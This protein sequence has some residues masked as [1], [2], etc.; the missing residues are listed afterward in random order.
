MTKYYKKTP[1]AQND[2][3]VCLPPEKMEVGVQYA[4]SWNLV[5]QPTATKN[6]KTSLY[7]RDYYNMVVRRLKRFSHCEIIM[8]PEVSEHGWYHFH[9]VITLT[10]V[11]YFFLIDMPL[12]KHNASYKITTISDMDNI[13]RPYMYKGEHLLKPLC[14][15]FKIPYSISNKSNEVKLDAITCLKEGEFSHLND[16]YV[17]PYS[18]SDTESDSEDYKKKEYDIVLPKDQD[19]TEES[20]PN[21]EIVFKKK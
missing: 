12:L 13:W 8:Y 20:G 9:G 18:D 6:G 17:H 4:F 3:Y 2:R 1:S 21:G 15:E 19:P 5:E 10:N 14:K 7:L 11:I 16:I